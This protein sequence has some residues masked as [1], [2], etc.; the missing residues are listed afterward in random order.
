MR[1]FAV[2]ILVAALAG[3]ARPEGD[4][5]RARETYT[6]DTL[7]P[8]IGTVRTRAAGEPES[9]FVRTDEEREMHDRVW[10]FLTAPHSR[11]WF[12]N[13]IVEWQRTRIMTPGGKTFKDARYYEYLRREPFRSSRARYTR[14]MRDIDADISTM[15]KTFSAIC[16]VIEIDRRRI[17]AANELAYDDA[18]LMEETM[19]R[20]AENEVSINWFVSAARF[21]YNSYTLAL[22]RLLIETP[23]EEARS[24]DQRLSELAIL[25][26]RAERREFCGAID[27]YGADKGSGVIPSRMLSQPFTRDPEIRK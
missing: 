20:R 27:I 5:G 3:C 24:V 2:F 11:D 19:M 8:A 7:M 1:I 9:N 14:L 18:E 22:K 15:P 12:Q 16:A 26:E 13:I 6:H 21:R 23:H 10:R 25:V 4:L 17:T